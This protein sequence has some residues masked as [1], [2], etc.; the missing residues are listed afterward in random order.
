M[1]RLRYFLS[2]GLILLLVFSFGLSTYDHQFTY[3]DSSAS[4]AV[5]ALMHNYKIIQYPLPKGS[6]QPWGMTV[7]SQG[8][9]WFVEEQTNQVGMFDPRNSSFAE[10]NVTTPNSLL[11]EITAAPNGNVWFTEL[12]GE[13]L[14]QLNPASGV[15]REYGMPRGPDNLPCGPIGVTASSNGNIWV[16]CEFSNQIDEFFPSNSSF[17][18]FDLPVFFSAPLD[19]VFDHGGNFWFSAADSDMIG[20]VTV[21]DL[22]NGTS[23]GI[24]EFA[25]T[26]QT[27]LVTIT[28]SQVPNAS[29][30]TATPPGV[31]IV[32]SIQ[33]PSEIALSPDGSSL[34]ITEHVASSFDRYN[35]NSKS[36]IKYW[37]SQTYS[38]SYTTSLP[39]GIAVDAANHVWI[40][41]H[42]G[43]KIA[44]FNPDTGQM[45]EYPIPC[46]GN[47]IAGT[48]YLALGLNGSVW[49]TEFYGNA[50]GELVP[51]S[52]FQPISLSLE[53]TTASVSSYGE[54]RIPVQTSLNNSSMN[55]VKV[56]FFI[57]GISTTG[58]MESSTALFDP[59]SV[60]LTSGGNLS[61][62]LDIKTNGLNP[63]TY[64]LTVG[65]KLSTT[66]VIYSTILKLVVS[67][68]SSKTLLVEGA[69]AGS[70]ASVA[71]VGA[72]VVISRR[73]KIRRN[74][75][76]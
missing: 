33:T 70:V 1:S 10:Y 43:N 76:R 14:G 19:I 62:T 4:T 51:Q 17:L 66:G 16:T 31:K 26:N 75:R 54:V 56:T 45:V 11:E 73:P 61:T 65:G 49:F 35:I 18:S 27:Y 37:T 59:P 60:S 9:V 5:P 74:K 15:I 47:G 71:V 57:S 8:R 46:C 23:N 68:D 21:A 53:N 13:S 48:L 22:K 32:S 39:N 25:P 2:I 41:E 63:G 7:D 44:E 42:Y 29:D 28:N 50:I 36:L 64:Y 20:Y 12:T 24:N 72:L 3:S 40:A 69:I 67:P 30:L 52:T 38:S 58:K 34:W 6:S 55:S